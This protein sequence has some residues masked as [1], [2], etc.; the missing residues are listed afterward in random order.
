MAATGNAPSGVG[1]LLRSAFEEAARLGDGWCRHV[2]K[3]LDCRTRSRPVRR[4]AVP[5]GGRIH[6][7]ASSAERE[8]FRLCEARWPIAIEGGSPVVVGPEGL[9]D[10]WWSWCE[11][12]SVCTSS[13]RRHRRCK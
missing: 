4:M 10:L 7:F 13:R 12:W 8:T 11:G 1:G 6:V 2:L 5:P 9:P 3:R